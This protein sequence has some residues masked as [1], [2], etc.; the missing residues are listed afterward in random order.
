MRKLALILFLL[1]TAGVVLAATAT[2]G[3]EGG[4]DGAYPPTKLE[5]DGTWSEGGDAGAFTYSYPITLPSARGS[6]TPSVTLDYDSQSVDGTTA[7]TQAQANWL[8]DG[9]STPANFIEQ[10]YEPCDDNPEAVSPAPPATNDE[11]Y[12]GQVLSLSLNFLAT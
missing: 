5:P 7:T 3:S 4:A 10:S 9:W 1:A 6:L 8:G 12:D 11:C 2:T